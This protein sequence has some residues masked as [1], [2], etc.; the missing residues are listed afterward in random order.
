MV[1]SEIDSYL[2]ESTE[3]TPLLIAKRDGNWSTP[4]GMVDY[5]SSEDDDQVYAQSEDAE[6]ATLDSKTLENEDFV[7]E[8]TITNEVG[9]D[10]V[11]V[12]EAGKDEV[13]S[14]D[15]KQR[16]ESPNSKNGERRDTKKPEIKLENKNSKSESN[17]FS[18]FGGLL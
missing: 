2:R 15:G 14:N 10:E 5:S 16:T 13:I 11:A 3:K 12:N 1:E 18:C 6:D 4:P 7:E 17:V 9:K 8:P